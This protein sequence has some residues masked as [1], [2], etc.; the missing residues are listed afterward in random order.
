[1]RH[2]LRR[3]V[4][5]FLVLLFYMGPFGW[6]VAIFLLFGVLWLAD[7]SGFFRG[8]SAQQKRNCPACGARNSVD[9]AACLYCDEPLPGS[10]ER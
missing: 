7:L 4:L 9:R 2:R 10:D 5:A 1:V 8:S 6:V 3:T